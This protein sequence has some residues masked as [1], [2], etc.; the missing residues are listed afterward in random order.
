[1]VFLALKASNTD[2]LGSGDGFGRL[3]GSRLGVACW[4][5]LIVLCLR[6]IRPSLEVAETIDNRLY[7][8]VTG[9]SSP[10]DAQREKSLSSLEISINFRIK[11]PATS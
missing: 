4:D 1:M 10:D 9:P 3:M 2:A 7:P 5:T 8:K 6:I 11:D